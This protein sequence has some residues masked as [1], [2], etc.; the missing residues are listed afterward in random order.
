MEKSNIDIFQLKKKIKRSIL[1]YAGESRLQTMEVM[2]EILVWV[3][4]WTESSPLA[5]ISTKS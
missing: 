1:G 3:S 2:C 5:I 4:I